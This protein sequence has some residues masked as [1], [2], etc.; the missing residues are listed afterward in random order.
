MIYYMCLSL[1]KF[2]CSKQYYTALEAFLCEIIKYN[3]RTK[4]YHEFTL[5]GGVVIRVQVQSLF[6][7][8]IINFE[9]IHQ[10]VCA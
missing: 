9:V 8:V 2:L 10:K 3:S 7:L 5:L 6:Q 1:S 4:S